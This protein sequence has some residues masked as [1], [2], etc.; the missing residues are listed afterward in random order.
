MREGFAVGGD[1]VPFGGHAGE[2]EHQAKGTIA[3]CAEDFPAAAV[4]IGH[5]VFEG[6]ER[7]GCAH[8]EP[9]IA[10]ADVHLAAEAY[11]GE[12]ELERI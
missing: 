11:H 8:D 12:F 3:F 10:V 6:N 4:H 9:A 1:D 5:G 7:V 2:L